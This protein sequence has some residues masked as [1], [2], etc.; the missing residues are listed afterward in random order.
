MAII[1]RSPDDLALDALLARLSAFQTREVVQDAAVGFR[2][3]R[4]RQTAW[5]DL[6]APLVVLE[7]DQDTPEPKGSTARGAMNFTAKLRAI[8]LVPLA[9]DPDLAASRLYYLKEQ[10]RT[11]I[12]AHPGIDLGSAPGVLNL[13]K[14]TW[15][16]STFDDHE[17]EETVL[18]G[19]WSFDLTY[20]WTPEDATGTALSELHVTAGRW[21]AVYLYGD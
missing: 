14:P 19:V 10:V 21:A 7:E 11:A 16:R 2:F 1:S 8:C 15:S 20:P 5:G 4:D 3:E 18:V 12:W 13:G 9:G 6:T 17:L